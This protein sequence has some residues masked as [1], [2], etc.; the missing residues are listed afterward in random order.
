MLTN[1]IVAY[2]LTQPSITTIVGQSIQP[3]PAP[4]EMDE[5]PAIVYQVASD[6][7]SDTGDQPD[8]V[9]RA[10]IV[11][12]CLAPYGSGGY[13]IARSLALAVKRALSGYSGVLPD[14]TNVSRTRIV[15]STDNFDDNAKLSRSSVHVMFTY[16]D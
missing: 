9:T 14:G 5:Y 1:G 7:P 11:F 13:L 15:N 2:L 4:V 3:I 16:S 6:V 12:D 10:R 8:G